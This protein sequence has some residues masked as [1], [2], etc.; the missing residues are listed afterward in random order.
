ML[1]RARRGGCEVLVRGAGPPVVCLPG[2]M[3]SP[4]LFQPL[5]DLL[6][7]EVLVLPWLEWPGP[8]DLDRVAAQVVRVLDATGPAVV[9]GHSTGGA[10]ALLAAAVPGHVRGLVLA[11]T[12]V[13]MRGHADVDAV[14]EN[15]R[16]GW[17]EDLWE[18]MF[19]RLVHHPVPGWLASELRAYPARLRPGAVVE[20]LVSQR[21]R[22]LSDCARA[23][24]VPA[25]VVNGQHDRARGPVDV[26]RLAELL[27][28]A[29]TTVDSGH[30]P[31]AEV[32]ERF[33]A[34][35]RD[36]IARA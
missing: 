17:G 30:S 11:G 1:R 18:G 5:A 2:T 29:A 24:R 8:H 21:D 23:V 31:C 22:D 36:V 32:P 6:D 4:L 34:V 7:A 27:G 3:A 25:A 15:T 14:I 35:V 26:G 12:G 19:Q 28:V 20:A 33:A 13:D 16:T 9:V 10:L